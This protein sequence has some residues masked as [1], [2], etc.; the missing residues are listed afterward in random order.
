MGM[1]S[2]RLSKSAF[3]EAAFGSATRSGLSQGEPRDVVSELLL[4]DC[5]AGLFQEVAEHLAEW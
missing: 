5:D 3:V 4:K 1:G 2:S